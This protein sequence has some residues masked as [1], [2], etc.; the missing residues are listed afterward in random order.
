MKCKLVILLLL[1]FSTSLGIAQPRLKSGDRII[2]LGDSIT[3][4]GGYQTLIKKVFDRFYPNLNLEIV[5]AGISGHKSPDMSARLQRDVIDKK[6]TI[7][8]ISCG[9]ND[10][11]HGFYTP[12]RGVELETYTRLMKQMV[13]Q[14]KASTHA[15]IYLLTPTVIYENLRSPENLKLAAYCEAVRNIARQEK[16]DLV[17]LNDIFNLILGSTRIGGASEFHPTSD[18]VHMK[19]SGD[20]LIAAGILRAL[21]VPMAQILQ[22]T[23]PTVPAIHADDARLQ[24]WGR[25]D[26]R[27]ASTTGAVTVNTGSTILL[28]F[29]GS[30]LTLHFTTMQ[31]SHQFP[32]LW[33]QVDEGE[34][35]VVLPAEELRLSKTPLGSGAHT[36]RLVVKGFRE[37]ENRWDTPLVNSVIFRGVTPE[38]DGRL[39]D[40]PQRP[41]K[42][43][44]YLGDSITEG[45]LVLGTPDRGTWT[46]D[47]WPKYSDGRRCW[48]YQ[49]ALLAGA[50]PRT[51]GFGRHGLSINANGGVPPGIES[52]PYIY[53]GAPID[54]TR[55]PDAVVINMGTNDGGRASSELF[56]AL[57]KAYVEKIRKTYPAAWILCMR[58]FNGAHAAVIEATVARLADPKVRFVDTSGWIV[59]GNHTREDFPPHFLTEA[60]KR[61][62]TDCF[63]KI[64]DVEPCCHT[65]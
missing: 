34:W 33:L 42:L 36:A 37:W 50:E 44:E 25:W 47:N 16:V 24:F 54:Q 1:F 64:E 17:D 6:P 58:P 15:A 23:E 57:Y 27:N 46:R 55:E 48:A 62:S 41:A 5:N 8:T 3:E 56:A 30:N 12:P 19:S 14:V 35:T 26:H 2:T 63:L 61:P 38:P 39:L 40:A 29:E 10:V 43:V 9:V 7:V 53:E 45:V 28:R 21:E 51:V 22:A 60:P 59:P 13:Q 11:W 20:F 32:S 31:Y 65:Q 52:F 18:G 4:A 49:S